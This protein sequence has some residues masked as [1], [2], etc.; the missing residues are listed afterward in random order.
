MDPGNA[1]LRRLL[2]DTVEA[3]MWRML[4]LAPSQPYYELS[5][6][7]KGASGISFTKRLVFSAWRVVPKVIAAIASYEAERRMMRLL[8][9]D[10]ENTPEARRHWRPLLRFGFSEGRLTGMPVLALVYPS[11]VLATVG[12][13][14]R[15]AGQ[16]VQDGAPLPD[17]DQAIA[18]VR[19]ALQPL[20]AQLPEGKPTPAP[21][22]AWY[23]AAPLLLDFLAEPE[24]TRGWLARAGAAG[25]W[26]GGRDGREAEASL[27]WHQH[28]ARA[29]QLLDGKI[30]LGTRPADLE[31]DLAKLALAGPRRAAP[32]PGARSGPGR[33]ARVACGVLVA[34]RSRSGAR[35]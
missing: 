17:T 23:W 25:A 7:Y 35:A 26:C 8:D 6:P 22:G 1:R 19:R 21:D 34:P 29:L 20:L 10:A 4:W 15:L 14:L 5:G 2:S 32:G 27:Y 31:D 18:A 11:V 13:P 33:L 16:R 9:S 30:E 24:A 3:G 28:V 12:D